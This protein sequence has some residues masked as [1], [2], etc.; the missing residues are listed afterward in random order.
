MILDRLDMLGGGSWLFGHPFEPFPLQRSLMKMPK[1]PI[2][3]RTENAVGPRTTPR[4]FL[5]ATNDNRKHRPITFQSEPPV[6]GFSSAVPVCS[7]G[8]QAAHPSSE[9][10]DPAA[11]LTPSCYP[12]RYAASPVRVLPAVPA[13]SAWSI[14][15]SWLETP[16]RS[17]SPLE[18]YC[19]PATASS[20]AYLTD[21]GT[22]P[23]AAPSAIGYSWLRHFRLASGSHSCCSFQIRS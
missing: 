22:L 3:L 8:S 18:H 23:V 20:A 15:S 2:H 19:I 13:C 1:Q 21:P 4:H 12:P 16:R 5:I 7:S 6:R 14:R 10:Y 17:I 11:P 9:R